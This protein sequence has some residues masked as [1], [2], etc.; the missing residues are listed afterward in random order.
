M[1]VLVTGG[2][3]YIGSH[4][5]REL[6][7]RG[8]TVTVVDNL[9]TGHRK[10]VDPRARFIHTAT[11]NFDVLTQTFKTL[12]IQAVLHFAANIEVA[13]SVGNPRKYYQ[14]NFTN[15]LHLLHAMQ[16]TGVKKIIF[17][18][19][20]AV[21]GEPQ[22]TPIHELHPRLPV[23][24]YGRSKHMTE[25]MI[26]DFSAA[27][28]INYAV[29]RYFNVAGAHPDGS[30]GEDHYPES[31]L[32]PRILQA[33]TTS[34]MEVKVFGNDYPTPDGTCVRD[35]IH[36]M[37]L[38]DAH[39]IALESLDHQPRQVYNLG[40]EKGFSVREII[41]AC[42]TVTGARLAVKEEPRREGDPAILVASSERIRRKL[43]W[44][45]KYPSIEEIV[46]HAWIWRKKNPR[47]YQDSTAE[48]SSV[49][50]AGL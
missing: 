8:H 41:T 3:G 18:S 19:T 12:G 43:G 23:N 7:D 10:A 50:P 39:I 44:K 24:P 20:A 32:I 5:V 42:E 34:A 35:Y 26:E 17:S 36:V 31:H 37:D 14:N 15:T 2:A 30:L 6:L 48:M 4:A 9:S 28:G 38:I 33:A 25:M 40:S 1:R 16:E 27:Y 22:Y 21:Y 47:G 11:S 46:R 49:R 13:E 45:R 29:L